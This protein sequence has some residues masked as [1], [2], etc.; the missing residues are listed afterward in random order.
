MEWKFKEDAEPQGSS[1]G[2]WY[3]LTDGGYIRPQ[4]LLSD[5]EQLKKLNE[6]ISLVQSFESALESNDLLDEF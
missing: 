2:F 3:D 4:F 6:A 1:D 5:P